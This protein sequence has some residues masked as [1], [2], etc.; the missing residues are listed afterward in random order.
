MILTEWK[1]GRKKS[2]EFCQEKENERIKANVIDKIKYVVFNALRLFFP[3]RL[4]FYCEK[5]NTNV[6]FR[7]GAFSP[8]NFRSILCRAQGKLL[9][10]E[11][12]CMKI[13]LQQRNP[14]IRL[15][16]TTNN[17]NR[18]QNERKKTKAKILHQSHTFP[19]TTG[20]R[21]PPAKLSD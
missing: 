15:P 1:K 13:G 12:Y 11:T 3:P 6:Y 2:Q 7:G 19:E 10:E 16:K 18:Q 9:I 4:Q 5:R 17:N 20:E 8:A 14:E 21:A